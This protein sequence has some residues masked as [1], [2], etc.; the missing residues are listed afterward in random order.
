MQSVYTRSFLLL[1]LKEESRDEA[2]SQPKKMLTELG[3][4]GGFV[5]VHACSL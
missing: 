3:G 2:M 4:G 5:Q 1:P